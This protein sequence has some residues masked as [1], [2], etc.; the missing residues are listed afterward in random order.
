MAVS[1]NKVLISDSVNKKCE[2]LLKAHGIDVVTKFN[3]SPTELIKELET[4][5]GLIVRSETKVTKEIIVASKTLRVIG[6]AGT[7]VDNIDID[8]ATRKGIIV[9]NA[10]NG[11]SISACELT[12]SFITSLARN[13]TVACQSM[14][15]G[16][17]DR[18]AFSGGSELSGKTL[19]IIGLG[20]IGKEV[21]FRMRAFDMQIVGYD[22]FVTAE[23][24][25]TYSIKRL[26]LAD[27]WS[28]SD[29][30][31][32]HT[33]LIQQTKNLINQSVFAQCKQG[34]K[35]IN[36]ARGGIINEKDLL[37]ALEDGIC[38]GAALDV[39]TEEPPTN[40]ITKKLISH[41]KVI[42]TPHIG[43][44]TKE[45]QIRVAVEVAEQF[46]SLNDTNAEYKVT[47]ILNAPAFLASRQ[48]EN[49]G[50]LNLAEQLGRIISKIA[51]EH[52]LRGASIKI[53]LIGTDIT[54]MKFLST[55]VLLGI[56]SGSMQNGYNLIN[57]PLYAKEAGLTFF[58]DECD[59][60][61][62]N[63]I[64]RNIIKISVNNNEIPFVSVQGT[65]I[66]DVPYLLQI[67][68]AVFQPPGV[69]LSKDISIYHCEPSDMQC[70]LNSIIHSHKQINYLSMGYGKQVWIVLSN[71]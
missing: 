70:N 58:F 54:N 71:K 60:I 38:A 31:T 23:E 12:C 4:C 40:E 26:E 29:Y 35:I 24:A 52:S 41:P 69:H 27:I 25:N 13:V 18:K 5:N 1:I 6:R 42:A 21:A 46:I 56:L 19:A 55:S 39:Y 2:E 57:S 48:S 11:N 62:V 10:P 47:G 64:F 44:S 17:W 67:N 34:V 51:N 36:A 7:G 49:A 37:Q 20:K 61:N 30:I 3:L 50:W 22:P 66:E 53:S 43:A 65:I 33:P 45:A 68:D 8:A 15:E 16:R 28:I 14:K 9:L 59:K 32:I 63:N